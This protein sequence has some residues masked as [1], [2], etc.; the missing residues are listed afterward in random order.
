MSC[1]AENII[2]RSKIVSIAPKPSNP[3]N[4]T[5]HR[6][7]R[8]RPL[9]TAEKYTLDISIHPGIPSQPN[10]I[11]TQRKP[12]SHMEPDPFNTPTF[13]CGKFLHPTHHPTLHYHHHKQSTPA[14]NHTNAPLRG[15]HLCAPRKK[16]LGATI[17]T[18]FRIATQSS[19]RFTPCNSYAMG[20]S[21]YRSHD[22][23]ECHQSR[24]EQSN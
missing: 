9:P 11:R 10:P 24:A 1:C 17:A 15:P 8:R 23:N 7:P 16:T 19:F 3:L 18:V 22:I 4:L 2:C 6:Q 21:V 14:Q 5:S 13:Q 12:L 20:K